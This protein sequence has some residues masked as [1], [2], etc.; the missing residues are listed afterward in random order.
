MEMKHYSFDLDD[1]VEKIHMEL[2]TIQ[3]GVAGHYARFTTN[4]PE[5][6]VDL[7]LERIKPF[8]LTEIY[9]SDDYGYSIKKGEWLDITG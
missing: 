2:A 6:A 5:E 8:L 9:E 3:D 4:S 7:L 1:L